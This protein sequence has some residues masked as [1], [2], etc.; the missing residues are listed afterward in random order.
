MVH[1]M[2]RPTLA[3]AQGVSLLLAGAW[4]LLHLR[5]FEWVLGPKTDRWLVQTVAGLL[6][7]N[8]LSQLVA[9]R[10]P[11]SVEVARVLGLSTSAALAAIDLVHVP[12]GRISKMYLLDAAGELGWIALWLLSRPRAA[13]SSATWTPG[14]RA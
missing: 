4:P 13:G 2:D 5:S 8:G 3:R 10:N 11:D 9:A 7:G 12:R 1:V 14:R 6:V